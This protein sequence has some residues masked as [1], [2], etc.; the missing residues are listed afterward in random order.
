[1]LTRAPLTVSEFWVQVDEREVASAT[2]HKC[3]DRAAVKRADK[4]VALP[5]VADRQRGALSG[6]GVVL[7]RE[8]TL[9]GAEG[10]PLN[11]VR[12]PRPGMWARR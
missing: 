2:F 6:C 10:V 3:A 12:R 8:G 11:R 4:Q 1:V 9:V 5:E 7:G